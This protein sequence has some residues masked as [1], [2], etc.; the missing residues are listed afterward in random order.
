MSTPKYT[1]EQLLEKIVRAKI[2]LEAIPRARHTN[3]CPIEDDTSYAPCNCG[4]SD[5]HRPI[6]DA[7]R[8]LAL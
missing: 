7:I 3:F 1:Y 4:A 5:R 6:E 2:M 8:A